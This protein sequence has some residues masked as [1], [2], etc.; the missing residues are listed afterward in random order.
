MKQMRVFA[1]CVFVF[2]FALA[3]LLALMSLIDRMGTTDTWF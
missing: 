1:A 3:L 2:S